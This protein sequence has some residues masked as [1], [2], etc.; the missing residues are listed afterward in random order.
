M[1]SIISELILTL[2]PIAV[3]LHLCLQRALR[4]GNLDFNN[5]GFYSYTINPLLVLAGML[6]TSLILTLCLAIKSQSKFVNSLV[7]KYINLFS[8]QCQKAPSILPRWRIL[9]QPPRCSDWVWWASE[10]SLQQPAKQQFSRTATFCS[11]GHSFYPGHGVWPVPCRG[12]DTGWA[13][14]VSGL[15]LWCWGG[16]GGWNRFDI[17]AYQITKPV[18]C[19]G[20][21]QRIHCW[22]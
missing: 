13:E 19:S 3:Q 14:A 4:S 21:G 1:N 9:C 16:G 15:F 17:Q 10:W 22:P 5:A 7:Y 2:F 11:R 8:E 12:Y 18:Q 20:Q 6:F